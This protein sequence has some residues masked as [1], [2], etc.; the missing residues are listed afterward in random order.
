MAETLA[1][2]LLRKGI[3][4]RSIADHFGIN[5]CSVNLVIHGYQSS[6]RILGRIDALMGWQPGTAGR[7]AIEERAQRSA[8]RKLEPHTTTEA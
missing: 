8:Q 1:D 7:M 2:A 5:S 6:K 4:Q 3:S